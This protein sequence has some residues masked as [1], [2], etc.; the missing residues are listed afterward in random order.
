MLETA[1]RLLIEIRIIWI[2]LKKTL[3]P[4]ICFFFQ[5]MQTVRKKSPSIIH[6]CSANTLGV[7][8][9]AI[10]AHCASPEQIL[11]FLRCKAVEIGAAHK[12]RVLGWMVVNRNRLGLQRFDMV[13]EAT[14]LD[15]ASPCT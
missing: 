5:W 4:I 8:R 10:R 15:L 9:L 14:F 11:T 3:Y 1:R 7:K 13:V 12:H 6:Q 2:G